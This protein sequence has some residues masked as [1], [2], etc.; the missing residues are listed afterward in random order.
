MIDTSG[1][2]P[3]VPSACRNDRLFLVLRKKKKKNQLQFVV[4]D[5]MR[6][7]DT[8]FSSSDHEPYVDISK[9]R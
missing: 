4:F 6:P 1:L 7:F 9:Y 8:D 3:I 5:T 2:A